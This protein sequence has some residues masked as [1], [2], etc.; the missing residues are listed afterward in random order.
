VKWLVFL[1]MTTW[2]YVD[3]PV[4]SIQFVLETGG[5]CSLAPE[6]EDKILSS[7]R[8]ADGLH[9]LIFGLNQKTINGRIAVCLAPVM[10]ITGVV[11][12]NPDG[13]NAQATVGRIS[14]PTG[15]VVVPRP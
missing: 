11:A 5:M 13:T 12:A 14:S 1:A 3:R 9:V 8:L 2:I 10:G 15:A 4:C 7:N 6:I